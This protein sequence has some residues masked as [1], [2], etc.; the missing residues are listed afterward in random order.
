[1]DLITQGLLG[2]TVAQA[3]AK[4]DELQLASLVGFCAP[5]LADADTLLRSAEDP[6]LFLENHRHFTPALA[7]IPIGALVA[8]L[9]LWP[10]L[11]KR[12]AFKRIYFYALL[13]YATAGILD[14]CTSYGTHLLW[15]FSDVRTAWSI[16]SIFDPLFSLGLL[17]ALGIGLVKHKPGV[18]KIGLAFA[19]AYLLLGVMQQHRAASLARAEAAETGHTVERLIV[20]PT[21]GNL[22]LW[23][24][25]YQ[26]EGMYYVDAVRVGLP[27][28]SRVFKGDM[29]D[30]FDVSR[31][32]PRLSAQTT[33]YDDIQRF[34]VFSDGFL[35]WHPDQ[36]NVLGDVRYAMLPTSTRPLWGIT[37]NL[38]APNEHVSFDTY[39]SL[40][41]GERKA[42]LAMLFE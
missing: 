37:L 2:A 26:S 18:A 40:S 30:V 1:M 17:L 21:M 29:V 16:I 38:D 19:G 12:L 23:R 10:F 35:A 34:A 39:R 13:G 9:L 22:V 4:R 20:K 25:V 8:S 14:A 6:L 24:S 28:Q 31:D 41:A 3:G 5:L 33:L 42:F 32:L 7:F 27:N 11:K 36:P 15:P